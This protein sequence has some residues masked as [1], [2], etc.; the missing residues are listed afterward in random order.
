VNV[1]T[2]Q[3]DRTKRRFSADFSGMM[4]SMRA[5]GTVVAAVIGLVMLS[6]SGS[7]Q[8]LMALRA[9]WADLQTWATDIGNTRERELGLG[10]Q[11]SGSSGATMLAFMGRV[12]LRAP[13][14]P[15]REV[16]AQIAVG[17]LSNPN[18]VR[19]PVLAFVINPNGEKT[20]Q[21]DLS[22]MLTVDDSTPGGSAQN[23]VAVFAAAD[24]VRLVE[25]DT[26]SAN[27]FGF[28]ADLRTDQ[29]KAMKDFAERLHLATAR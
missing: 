11:L 27:V 19:R 3:L 26:L 14:V 12:N 2:N 16:V 5:F 21:L 8:Q 7:A 15:P 23:G 20:S 18:V 6:T 1:S 10:L 4:N 13:N 22:S 24:F 9:E 17:S 25:A 29:I 28:D